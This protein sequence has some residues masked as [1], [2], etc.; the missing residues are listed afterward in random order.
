MH[1]TNEM[2]AYAESSELIENNHTAHTSENLILSE[3]GR[4]RRLFMLKIYLFLF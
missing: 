3:R 1:A 2:H 4:Q